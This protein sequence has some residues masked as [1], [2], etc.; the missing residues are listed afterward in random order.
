MP[1]IA[2][3][4]AII[5]ELENGELHVRARLHLESEQT[6][7]ENNGGNMNNSEAELSCMDFLP[8]IRLAISDVI[9]KRLQEEAGLNYDLESVDPVSTLRELIEQ[10]VSKYESFLFAVREL[11]SNLLVGNVK[12]DTSM[13]KRNAFD[14]KSSNS[15]YFHAHAKDDPCIDVM[16]SRLTGDIAELVSIAFSVMKTETARENDGLEELN[17]YFEDLRSRGNYYA[18]LAESETMRLLIKHA[19][20]N[21]ELA[22]SR[23]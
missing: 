2:E 12:W 3:A 11:Y 20:D 19:K 8:A 14:F 9:K 4:T 13:L 18:T 23:Y 7:T 22:N 6:G 17:Q 16:S 21:P 10:G 5:N 1:A 15:F